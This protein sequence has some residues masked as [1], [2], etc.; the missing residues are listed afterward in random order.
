VTMFFKKEIE[1]TSNTS[2]DMIPTKDLLQN[3]EISEIIQNAPTLPEGK[4]YGKQEI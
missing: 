1:T 4:M 2:L 3:E